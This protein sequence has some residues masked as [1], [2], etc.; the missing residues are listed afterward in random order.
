MSYHDKLVMLVGLYSPKELISAFGLIC[1]SKGV[2]FAGIN[3]TVE[4]ATSVKA[5]KIFID[6][7][8]I[9]DDVVSNKD[10]SDD[11]SDNSRYVVIPLSMSS[12]YH[13]LTLFLFYLISVME[14]N[15]KRAE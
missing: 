10:S 2:N 6:T 1:A 4:F 12:A 14:K 13:V 9:P 11:E 7:C 3:T 15:I 8:M 5:K